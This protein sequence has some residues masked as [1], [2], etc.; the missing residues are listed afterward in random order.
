MAITAF[1]VVGVT[2]EKKN[3]IYQH[4]L[5]VICMELSV[6]KKMFSPQICFIHMRI[7]RLYYIL[8]LLL[9]LFTLYV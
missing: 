6:A 9:L 8:G 3:Q 7:Y 2:G 4:I 5:Y 1:K